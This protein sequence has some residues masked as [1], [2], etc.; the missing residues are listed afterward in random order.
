MK[1]LQVYGHGEGEG[2][3]RCANVAHRRRK[4]WCATSEVVLKSIRHVLVL[5]DLDLAT[6][7]M[8]HGSVHKS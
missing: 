4:W 6:A 1:C 2:Q 3:V 7:A 5:A 8:K